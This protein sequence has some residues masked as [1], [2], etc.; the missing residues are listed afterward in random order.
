[1]ALYFFAMYVLGASLGPVG[2]G[3]ASDYFTFQAAS[4]AG[5]VAAAAVRRVDAGRV[6]QPGRR[7]QGIRSPSARAVQ[8]ARP[9]HGDVHRADSRHDARRS[10]CSP[11]RERSR[12]TSSR[13]QAWMRS[14]ASAGESLVSREHQRR[15][16]PKHRRVSNW[17]CGLCEPL[18]SQVLCVIQAIRSS[19]SPAAATGSAARCAAGSPRK[20]ARAVVVVGPRPGRGATR[21]PA[22]SA[23]WRSKPMSRAKADVAAPRRAGRRSARR[24]RSVLLERRHRRWTATSTRQTRNGARCWDVNVMAH[25]YAARAVLPGMLRAG[26]GLSAA[27]GVG[28]RAC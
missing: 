1:M 22:R 26:R 20:R 6:P 10:S 27:D 16:P 14:A 28:G 19:S 23:G 17:L 7:G 11:R 4:A 25:V 18:R 15:V 13:L 24:H 21:S 12:R 2:T 3:L 5:A 8:S 9:A